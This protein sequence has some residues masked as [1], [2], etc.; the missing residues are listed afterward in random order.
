MLSTRK[1]NPRKRVSLKFF[2]FLLV[3]TAIYPIAAFGSTK[4]MMVG[5]SITYGVGGTY[6]G[7]RGYLYDLLNYWSYD[8]DFVGS[9]TA[10]SPSTIDP[11]HEG[12]E[13]W[14]AENIRDNI[15]GWLINN[16]AELILLH[17]GTND[18]GRIPDG[19][20]EA[21]WK[22]QVQIQVNEVSQILN[23]IDDFS[24]NTTVILARIILRLDEDQRTY[25]TYFNQKLQDMVAG[26][27]SDN[28]IVV[29]MEN[30]AGLIYSTGSGGDMADNL[31][32]NNF[33]YEKM[34]DE[35]YSAV[36]YYNS[37]EPCRLD[38]RF[39][40]GSLQISMTY[41]TDRSYVLTSIPSRYLGMAAVKT[42]NDDLGRSDESN[43]LK[44]RMPYDAM[45]YVAY[46]S[47]AT[48]MPNWLRNFTY[49]GDNLYTSLASQDHLKIYGK[50]FNEGDCVDLGANYAAGSSGEYRSNFLVFYGVIGSAPACVLAPKFQKTTLA[51]NIRYYTDRAYTLS[52]VPA[53][54][55]G[56]AL[57]KT[58][59][60]DLN[61]TTASGYLK[62]EM[63]ADGKVFVAFDRRV[64]TL[65]AWMSGFT[66]TGKDIFTTLASQDHL[67]VYSKPYNEGDCVD[68]GANHA[69]GSSDEYR[70]NYVV[71]YG[72]EGATPPPP[73]PPPA[74]C[75]L[76]DKF[77][78]TTMQVGAPYYTDRDYTITGGI[79]TWMV[80]RTLIRTS[81]DERF[82][83]SS[84]GYLR[85]T[86]P[87]S[88]WVYV[89]FDSRLGSPPSWL[90]G[91]ELRSDIQ[92]KTS[93]SSQPY[94]KTYR[95]QFDAGQCVDLGGNYGPGS[96]S[97]NRS[98]YVVVYGQ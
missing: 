82:D 5:D 8:F 21:D 74:G 75:T 67:R 49:T 77:Q 52:D 72:Q 31:H 76:D 15:Y 14:R 41:Y 81:N 83:A 69:P 51:S 60:D 45:V 25:T 34:A 78:E 96:S 30:D 7:Y 71:F 79:P 4:I 93:L 95:K 46:D 42:P 66:Y 32:P 26:R 28:I 85:F 64:T 86:N 62:F 57:I 94:L 17:I 47:R 43:Y 11:D 54:Y 16:P 22:S 18:M 59:N 89:L 20:S 97:E 6:G 37:H 29:D 13:G 63:P 70:S 19:L 9:Q 58:P 80:G 65:P 88:W 12:Y 24:E 84:S 39:Q 40:E 68:L 98:N 23:R 53:E 44:F 90:N 33:G 48:S 2:I 36:S 55:S 91:W 87:D 92:I 38:S 3:L 35:W 61:L 73:P 1:M 50:A 56:L 10:N 27:S